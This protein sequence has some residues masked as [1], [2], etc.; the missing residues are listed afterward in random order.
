MQCTEAGVVI[1]LRRRVAHDESEST[2]RTVQYKL[3]AQSNE[4]IPEDG[5]G[6]HQ[7]PQ[8]RA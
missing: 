5:H 1:A 8:Q 2:G 4:Q 7:R 6:W 3:S